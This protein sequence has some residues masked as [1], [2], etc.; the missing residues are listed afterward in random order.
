MSKET[1]EDVASLAGRVLKREPFADDRGI[2]SDEYDELLADAKRLA[3]SA[4]AQYETEGGAYDLLASFAA[5]DLDHTEA[6]IQMVAATVLSVLIRDEGGGRANVR[7]SPQDMDDTY[8]HYQVE[9]GRDGL[10]TFVRI[11]PREGTAESLAAGVDPYPDEPA[12]PQAEEKSE[13]PVWTLREGSRL[14]I[15]NDRAGAEALILK[16]VDPTAAIENRYC[17][18]EDCPSERCNHGEGSDFYENPDGN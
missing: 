12:K 13:R 4:L 11:V 5:A 16:S 6:L 2:H 10:I 15:C 9:A 14:T 1:S 8:K 7:F 17:A 18:H 3:G